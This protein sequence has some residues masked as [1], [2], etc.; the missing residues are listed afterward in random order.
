MCTP[1][2]YVM[3]KKKK[4]KNGTHPSVLEG[5]CALIVKSFEYGACS[6]IYWLY[7]FYLPLCSLTNTIPDKSRYLLCVDQIDFLVHIIFSLSFFREN[8]NDNTQFIE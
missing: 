3:V 6:V 8:G 2:C 7:L 4:K 5:A 1:T